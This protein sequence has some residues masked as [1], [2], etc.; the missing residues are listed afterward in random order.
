MVKE[1]LHYI[2]VAKG[3]LILMVA[4]G[5]IYGNTSGIDNVGVDYIHQ[6]VNLFVSF[7]MPC[8]FVITGY[9]GSHFMK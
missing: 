7:Y 3:L 6:S 4:Y 5:H 8:F 1:R 2:D 9:L